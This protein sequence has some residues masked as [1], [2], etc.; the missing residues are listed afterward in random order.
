MS[1]KKILIITFSQ[2]NECLGLV[3]KAL[4]AKNAQP[5]RFN[6]DLF[7]TEVR[8]SLEENQEGTKWILSL[9]QGEL[10]LDEVTGVWYRRVRLGEKLPAEMAKQLREPSILESREVFFGMME[11]LG[12]KTFILDPCHRVKYASHKQLQL[13]VAREV[14]LEIPRTLTT[15]H[16]GA[17]REFIPTCENGMIAKMLSSFSVY[18]DEDKKEKVVYTNP[19]T[20]ED[21]ED[22]SG[23][24][25]CPMTFQENVPK[26]LELRIT[27]VG[28]RIFAAAVD[29]G[30]SPL[31]KNDW[32]RDGVGLIRSWEF[33][34]LPREI[35]VKLLRLMAVFGL[36]YGAVDMI[37]TPDNRY[38]FLEIN[39][40]GEF[41]WLELNPPE[42]PISAAIADVLTGE[43]KI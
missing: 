26:K 7:P 29:S 2:D 43:E 30:K 25:L 38:V 31:G 12:K 5:Y 4:L 15:N 41:F 14:G 21:L 28:K 35:E 13:Q 19:V 18:D 24:S 32:R 16:P 20:R 37:L 33:H 11:A 34:P 17:V 36:N 1:I 39:P 22:L 3:E 8:I 27:I 10:D 40:A 6:T 42:F 23:L 9:P